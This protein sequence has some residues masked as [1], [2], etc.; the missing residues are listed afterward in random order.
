MSSY[1]TTA[2]AAST[3]Q[4]LIPNKIA[5]SITGVTSNVT[6]GNIVNA[7]QG[8]VL[9]NLGNG[10]SQTGTIIVKMGNAVSWAV[11][12]YVSFAVEN[13]YITNNTRVFLSPKGPGFAGQMVSAYHYYQTPG[14]FEV[15]LKTVGTLG[16]GPN[17]EL[18]VDYFILF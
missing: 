7:N 16:Y 9:P 10:T 4:T 12:G 15:L 3:Y 5:D 1:L 11:G 14:Y 2:N 6:S 13:S 17:E 18:K 8:I